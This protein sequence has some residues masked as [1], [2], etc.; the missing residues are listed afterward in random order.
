LTNVVVAHEALTIDLRPLDQGAPAQVEAVYRLDNAGAARPLELWLAWYCPAMPGRPPVQG[1]LGN[2]PLEAVPTQVFRLPAIFLQDLELN[3][4]SLSSA[5]YINY[6]LIKVTLPPRQHTLKLRYEVETKKTDAQPT[7]Q[8]T[9]KYLLAP[10]LT[11]TKFGGLEL[12]VRLPEKWKAESSD[13]LSREGDELHAHFAGVAGNRLI[14]LNVQAP[15]PKY[16][17]VLVIAGYGLLL[18]NVLGGVLLCRR[19]GRRQKGGD[20]VAAL[21]PFLWAGVIICNGIFIGLGPWLAIPEVQRPDSIGPWQVL[22]GFLIVVLAVVI[23]WVGYLITLNSA[24][25][26]KGR[27]AVSP[28]GR[29]RSNDDQQYLLVPEGKLPKGQVP[30][31]SAKGGDQ[32]PVIRQAV[33]GV[34]CLSCGQQIPPETAKCL[35]CGWT[36][37]SED[38]SGA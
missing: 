38:G 31:P 35:A 27:P 11:R 4:G 24:G 32:S 1:W 17:H 13:L 22:Q 34:P 7:V 3:I 26:R 37:A 30:V 14:V 6:Y 20:L 12:T 23:L 10:F 5:R 21:V 15:G 29:R 25:R 8:R 16:G 18:V 33:S 2:E 9:L 28:V 36:W 19:V